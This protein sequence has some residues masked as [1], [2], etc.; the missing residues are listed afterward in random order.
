[1]SLKRVLLRMDIIIIGTRESRKTGMHIVGHSLDTVH[2]NIL[3]QHAV[4][5]VG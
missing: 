5:L 1:M 3:R 4:K 2:G